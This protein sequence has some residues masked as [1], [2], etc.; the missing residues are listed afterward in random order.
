METQMTD[1]AA[2]T[3][4]GTQASQHSNGSQATADALYGDQQQASEGQDQQASEQANTDN[5]EANKDG[6]TQADKPQGAPEKYEFKAPE[7]KEFDAEIIGNF[8]EIAKELNLT[9][10]AAQKLVESMGP[11]IAERQLAQVE[12][13]RNEWAQ[14][15]QVDKEFGGDKLQENMAVAKKALDS[16]GTPELR[17]LLVQSGLGN[18]PE[19]IRFMYRAGK[20]ISEDTFVGS[21]PGAGGKPTGPQDFNAKAAALY[22]N[23]QS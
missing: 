7:G 20:A 5:P 19:V 23:Q 4:E 3:N 9:Q 21:S 13:I 1:T 8:S 14:Q 17:T 16:F 6:E 22:S 12:A 11:K 2:P 10:D 15:S 18:N